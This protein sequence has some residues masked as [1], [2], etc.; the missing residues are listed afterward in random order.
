M[1]GVVCCEESPQVTLG[2]GVCSN[3]SLYLTFF[4][5]APTIIEMLLYLVCARTLSWFV[6]PAITEYYTAGWHQQ[7]KGISHSSRGWK[8]KVKGSAGWVSSE[9]PLLGLWMVNVSLCPHMTFS[10]CVW[11]SGVMYPNLSFKKIFKKFCLF[12][13]SCAGSSLLCMGFL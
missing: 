3:N 2:A 13:L 7:Q 9:A 11:I 6:P 10:L 4:P 1:G 12:T 5:H 8:S